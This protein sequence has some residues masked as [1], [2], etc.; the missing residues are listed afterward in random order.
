MLINT[1]N[2]ITDCNN[3]VSNG[4]HFCCDE[5]SLTLQDMLWSAPDSDGCPNYSGN[6]YVEAKGSTRHTPNVPRPMRTAQAP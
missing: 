4:I 5:P 6:T 1:E 2:K 3:C